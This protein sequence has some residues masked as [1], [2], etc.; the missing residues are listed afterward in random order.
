MDSSTEWRSYRGSVLAYKEHWALID[1]VLYDLCRRFPTHEQRGHVNA[2][3]WLI[4]RTYQTGLERKVE[5]TGSQGGALSTAADHL[6][7]HHETIDGAIKSLHGL[8]EPLTPRHVA[9]I[10]SAHGAVN[11]LLSGITIRGQSTRSFVSKYLHFHCPLMPIYDSYAVANLRKLVRWSDSLD[12]VPVIEGADDEYRWFVLR[13]FA[14]YL[15]MRAADLDPVATVRTVD[16]F[17][18]EV[19]DAPPPSS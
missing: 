7:Q 4:G 2:K 12:V 14:L 6:H 11:R 1:E 17:L 10:I 13:F 16:R 18:V 5:S 19:G 8:Q 15:R 9:S 3:M